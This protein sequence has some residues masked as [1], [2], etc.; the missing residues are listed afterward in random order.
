MMKPVALQCVMGE[1]CNFKTMR[2]EFAQAFQLL[3][4]H[5]KYLHSPKA[6]DERDDIP[7]HD[8]DLEVEEDNFKIEQLFEETVAK[9]SD[10]ED[11]PKTNLLHSD[12]ETYDIE[13][14]K[15]ITFI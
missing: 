12:L 11:V 14:G 13:K 15:K 2:L 1:S 8:E 10:T 5:M 7:N 3:E 6:I 9:P 4:L